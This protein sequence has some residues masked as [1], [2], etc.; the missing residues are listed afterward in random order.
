MSQVQSQQTL[1]FLYVKFPDTYVDILHY[2]DALSTSASCKC[3]V[4]QSAIGDLKNA[5]IQFYISDM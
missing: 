5:N 2:Y 1:I 4:I 3:L